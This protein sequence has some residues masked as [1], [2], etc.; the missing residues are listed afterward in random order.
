MATASDVHR[1]LARDR[2]EA[3][4]LLQAKGL[5]GTRELLGD[6][7]R[8]LGRRLAA[9]KG[10]PDSFRA[11]QAKRMLTQVGVVQKGLGKGLVGL[12]EGLGEEAAGVGAEQT[13][14]ALVDGQKAHGG[15]P[16]ALREASMF[17][18]AVAGTRASILTRLGEAGDEGV[19]ARYGTKTVEA[20]EKRLQLGVATGKSLDEIADD[21]TEDS[22]FLQGAPRSWAE[23]ISRTEVHG[24]LSRA[25]SLA[26]AD[27]DEQLGDV[28]QIL[29]AVFD[30]RVGADSLAV[31]GQCRRVGEEFES[32]YGSFAAPPDRPN[33][34]GIV[35][36]QRIAW[37]IPPELKVRP[38]GDVLRAWKREGRKGSPPPRPE[39]M[40]TIPFEEFGKPPAKK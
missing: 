19:M 31:H 33:D 39:P 38:W 25:G 15:Q 3:Q 1:A 18:R 16:L 27:A 26:I 34:R 23:R 14:K 7:S 30:D 8:E 24:A 10:K 9:L 37:P 20:F 28:A 4:R 40:T 35:V 36:P 32:W 2:T 17:D 29:S 12:V 5:A 21:L 22:P 11:V 6:A 13:I